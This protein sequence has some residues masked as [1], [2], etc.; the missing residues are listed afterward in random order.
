MPVLEFR[1]TSDDDFEFAF[2]TYAKKFSPLSRGWDHEKARKEFT[3]RWSEHDNKYIVQLDGKSIGWFSC[4]IT[5]REVIV[6]NLHFAKGNAGFP[7]LVLNIILLEGQ[8]HNQEVSLRLSKDDPAID[9]FK[10]EGFPMAKGA[11][12]QVTVDATSQLH[13]WH[14]LGGK[15]LGLPWN[16]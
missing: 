7:S 13:H 1:D 11:D 16:K 15:K 3:R 9:F 4:V 12:G 8:E 14:R 6:D 2:D 10:G 5:K